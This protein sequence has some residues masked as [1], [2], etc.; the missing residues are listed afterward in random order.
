MWWIHWV[1]ETE[2][3]ENFAGSLLPVEIEQGS[4]RAPP[5]E[6]GIWVLGRECIFANFLARDVNIMD[7]VLMETF[8]KL[9][10]K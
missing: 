5:A 2:T 4:L 3:M 9:S 8:H 10:T 6:R 7:N 1:T